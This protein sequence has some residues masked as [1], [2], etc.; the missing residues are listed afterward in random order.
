MQAVFGMMAQKIEALE[1][2]PLYCWEAH[3]AGAPVA[4]LGAVIFHFLAV[5]LYSTVGR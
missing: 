1:E 4:Y 2:F 5:D 3:Y